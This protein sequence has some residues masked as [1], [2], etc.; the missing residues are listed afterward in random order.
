M[1]VV[2]VRA[3]RLDQPG[4]ARAGRPDADVRHRGVLVVVGDQEAGVGEHRSGCQRVPAVH[5]ELRVLPRRQVDGDPHVRRLGIGHLDPQPRVFHRLREVEGQRGPRIV[6]LPAVRQQQFLDQRA[7]RRREIRG[8]R[9]QYASLR[10]R[11]VLDEDPGRCLVPLE[12]RCDRKPQQVGLVQEPDGN[13]PAVP[14]PGSDG[15]HQ[16]LH[17]VRAGPAQVARMQLQ[18]RLVVLPVPQRGQDLVE[19][20]DFRSA[21]RNRHGQITHPCAARRIWFSS[22]RDEVG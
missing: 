18:R 7:V 21:Q 14:A 1:A 9:G 19:L 8:S 17:A 20:S 4:L 13:D 15:R 11:Q 16:F 3:Q 2:P 22:W 5:R 12:V 6:G 10:G